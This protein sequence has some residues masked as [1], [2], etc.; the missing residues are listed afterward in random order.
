MIDT[1][2]PPIPRD[3]DEYRWVASVI[4]SVE[5]LSGTKSRWNGELFEELEPGALGSALDDGGMTI[6]VADVLKPVALAYTA[7]R[8]LTAAELLEA[9]D[10]V[11]TVV[12]EAKHLTHALGD[13]NAPGAVPAY[14]PDALVLEEGLTETWAHRSVDAVIQ[15]IRMDSV[16]PGLVDAGAFDSYPAYTAATDDL[17]VGAADVSGLDSGDI[18][19]KLV[20]AERTGR[21]AAIADLVI[22][23]RL[24]EVMPAADRDAV[25]TQLVQ[26]MRP[27][28]ADVVPV[29]ESKEQTD[30][31]KTRAGRQAAAR[32]VVALSTTTAELE[33]RYVDA[34]PT[35]PDVEQ[36]RKFVGGPVSPPPGVSRIGRA[37]SAVRVGVHRSIG[38]RGQERD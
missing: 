19:D 11:L 29:Q 26:V 16:Q 30:D 35:A 2:G 4:R 10:A 6:A 23:Q 24:A 32:A 34:S 38:Q 28:L 9:R 5:E 7:N 21:L 20:Q 25:R 8:P 1:I 27:H 12:H 15:N 14:A 3:T 13:E 31:H 33:N 37:E 22:D 17:L 18:R 36:L